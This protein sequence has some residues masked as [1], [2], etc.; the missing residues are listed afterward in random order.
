MYC[1]LPPIQ[2]KGVTNVQHNFNFYFDLL[3]NKCCNLFVWKGLPDTVDVRALNLALILNGKVC[4]TEFNGKLYAL[5]G[6]VG[7]EPNAYYE[8][9]LFI[10]ANPILGSK[11]VKVRQDDGSDKVEGLNGIL[12]GNTDVDLESDRAIGG[13]YGLIYQYA[14]LLADNISSLNISQ[15]NGR[16]SQ[17]F[18]A[19]N[20]ELARTAELVLKEIYEGK[21][22][23]TVSQDILNKVGVLAAA[24]AGQTNTL[25]NL[26]E[27]H[28]FFLAQFYMELGI[29]SNYNMKRER[30][31]TAEVELNNGALDIN[32]W[33]ML[34][35][36]RN[37]IKKVN[38]LF[39]TNIEV[40]LNPEIFYDGSGNAS[41][42]T[43]QEPEETV[44]DEIETETKPETEPE[45]EEEEV[46]E[47]EVEI[48]EKGD[49][50][51]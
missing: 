38:E 32:V 7:G 39:G 11:T 2:Y 23:K 12:M 3:T 27:I 35:N 47:I 37:A 31:N 15:I 48:R 14:G 1:G 41:L 44:A 8:P 16:V 28:Q 50:D 13:L 5:S 30:L 42:G 17:I 20:E 26:M 22:Y 29:I 10:I 18:T 40:E 24:A 25:L 9:T 6:N 36:R 21:P 46:K 34:E 45:T 33:N 19:D 43:E 49:D 51:E 4:F